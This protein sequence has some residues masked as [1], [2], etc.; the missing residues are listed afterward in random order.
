MKSNSEEQ[1]IKMGG[2][3]PGPQD[4]DSGLGGGR[5]QLR[6]LGSYSRLVAPRVGRVN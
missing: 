1:V 3:S 4:S 5:T 2:W 6:R